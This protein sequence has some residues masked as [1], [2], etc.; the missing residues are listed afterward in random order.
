MRKEGG[1]E[2]IV[3]VLFLLFFCLLLRARAAGAAVTRGDE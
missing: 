1:D 2:K 3:G